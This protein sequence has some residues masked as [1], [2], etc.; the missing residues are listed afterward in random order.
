VRGIEMI[1]FSNFAKTDTVN[2]WLHKHQL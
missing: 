1:D 2:V